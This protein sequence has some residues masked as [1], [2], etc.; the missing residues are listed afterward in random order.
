M[1]K[2][3][4]FDKVFGKYPVPLPPNPTSVDISTTVKLLPNFSKL[5]R[6]DVYLYA[7]RKFMSVVLILKKKLVRR[8]Y[9]EKYLTYAKNGKISIVRLSLMIPRS[10]SLTFYLWQVVYWIVRNNGL[11]SY[12]LHTIQ[13]DLD[14]FLTA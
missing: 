8:K 13:Y 3:D 2:P 4:E 12:D 14:H 9:V 10:Y 5:C 7:Y 11:F 6:L 1:D